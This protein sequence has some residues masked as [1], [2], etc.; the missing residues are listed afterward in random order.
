VLAKF[1]EFLSRTSDADINFLLFIAQKMVQ[2]KKVQERIGK[3][4]SIKESI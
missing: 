4:T 3:K 1:R 2:K